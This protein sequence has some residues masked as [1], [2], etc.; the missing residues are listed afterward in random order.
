MFLFVVS[1]LGPTCFL[2]KKAAAPGKGFKRKTAEGRVP[3]PPS[4]RRCP[5]G[6]AVFL[7]V[8]VLALFVARGVSNMRAGVAS[9]KKKL[10]KQ[11]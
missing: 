8:L 5:R 11:D 6:A 9:T 2:G 3:Y 10:G 4:S 1:L 7:M